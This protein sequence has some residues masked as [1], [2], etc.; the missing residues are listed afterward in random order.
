MSRSPYFSQKMATLSQI[1][2]PFF[3]V[4]AHPRIA[5]LTPESCDFMFGNPQDMPVQGFVDALQKWS[6]PT[7]PTYFAYFSG[8]DHAQE[9]IARSLRDTLGRPYEAEDIIMTNGAFGAL[10]VTINAL[11]DEG[12]ELIYMLPPWFFYEGMITN[13]GGTPVAVKIREDNFDLDL[14]AIA[15]AI[16]AKTRAVLVNSP[17]NPTGKIYPPATLQALG[18][19]LQ[20]ASARNGRP[21]YLISDEAYSRILFDNNPFYSPTSYYANSILQSIPTAKRC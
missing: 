16:T 15:N 21:I 18:E 13:A 8:R 14:D 7:D 19:L 9:V 17:N 5:D 6:T 4:L 3:T 10:T 2:A 20:E 12:D 1:Q 11:I